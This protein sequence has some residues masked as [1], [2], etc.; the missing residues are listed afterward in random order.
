M[1]APPDFES[2]RS[3][4][5]ITRFVP[6]Y[7]RAVLDRLNRRL[8][9][10]LVVACGQ[11]PTRSSLRSITPTCAAAYKEVQLTNWW[12]GNETVHAQPYGRI[13]REC[14]APSVVLAEE[15]PRS[16]TLPFLLRH[17]RRRGAKL[18]LWGHFSSNQR[19]FGSRHPLDR[20]RI[21]LAQSVEGCVCYTKS[22]KDLLQT[23]VPEDRLFV[24]TN[25]VDTDTLDMLHQKLSE[26]GRK[27]V[28]RRLGLSRS[29]VAI[30]FI[31]RLETVKG[32]D[33]LLQTFYALRANRKATLFIIGAG[34]EEDSMRRY[35]KRHAV[36]D[37]RF[38]G[39]MPKSED[40][41]PYLYA[42]DVMLM[43]GFAGLAINH[44]FALGLPV[45][46]PRSPNSAFRYNAPEIAYL[47]D[48]QN[49]RLARSG[50]VED[51]I[52]AVEDVVADH[53]RY[54][55][56]ALAYAREHLTLRKMVDG[57]VEAIRFAEG[58]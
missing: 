52:A 7:R 57:L 44:S 17:A 29:E 5:Y 24:A 26:E 37:I 36:E 25:T 28:R 13:F 8:G 49:G 58:C 14:P 6:V 42:S 3:I 16:I 38:L 47:H 45:V 50:R 48:G 10:R 19:A 34:P 15:S 1:K 40:S 31:G 55:L 32:T 35:A 21:R 56:N 20:Y 4:V 27:A 33:Q 22:V 43:P 51:L 11:S 30:T 23:F 12:L 9:G 53:K 2:A 46:T 18:L 39:A 41:A 54:S